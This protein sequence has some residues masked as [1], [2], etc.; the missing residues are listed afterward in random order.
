[1][2]FKAMFAKRY[3]HFSRAKS[4]LFFEIVMPLILL[5]V[6]VGFSNVSFF[7]PPPNVHM[8]DN[9]YYPTP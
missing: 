2:Q 7:L 8:T 3:Y 4:E 5:L 1:M 9:T 6:G